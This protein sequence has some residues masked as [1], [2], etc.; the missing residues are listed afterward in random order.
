MKVKEQ[1][2]A[3]RRFEIG[4]LKWCKFFGTQS[5]RLLLIGGIRMK[6]VIS[7]IWRNVPFFPIGEKFD[8][9]N[10]QAVS[11]SSEMSYEP[12]ELLPCKINSSK[13]ASG[14]NITCIP[15]HLYQNSFNFLQLDSSLPKERKADH[16]NSLTFLASLPKFYS[17][18]KKKKIFF[19]SLFLHF[20]FFFLHPSQRKATS[21]EIMKDIWRKC[22]WVIFK[23]LQK[24]NKAHS[25]S[26][27]APSISREHLTAKLSRESGPRWK[28]SL[29]LCHRALDERWPGPCAYD[30]SPVFPIYR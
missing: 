18:K 21:R 15:I 13:R 27:W 7:N 16:K 24:W 10:W 26:L 4:E 9:E 20:F 1:K 23:A 8:A 3:V 2:S 19:P 30:W 12:R 14:S 6:K 22:G 11:G 17:E 5:P 29:R 28:I 25:S